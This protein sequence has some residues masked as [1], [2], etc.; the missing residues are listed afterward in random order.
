MLVNCS[1][2]FLKNDLNKNV[3]LCANGSSEDGCLLYTEH[4]FPWSL[5]VNQKSNGVNLS[6]LSTTLESKAADGVL[7]VPRLCHTARAGPVRALCQQNC[8]SDTA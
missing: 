3:L 2:N 4:V 7:Q 8:K 6:T 1:L 5:C